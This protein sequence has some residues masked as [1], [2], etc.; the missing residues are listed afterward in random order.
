[1]N[2]P[3]SLQFEKWPVE[4]HRRARRKNLTI[5]LYPDRPIQVRAAKGTPHAMILDFLLAK[6][7]WIEKNLS[8]FENWP[9]VESKEFKA[10]EDFPFKGRDL[11]L[12]PVI[13][14]N[15]KPFVSATDDHLLLHIPRNDWS[16]DR[17][18]QSQPEALKEIRL[19][20]KR[21]SVR[22]L[23]RRVRHWAHEMKLLPKKVGYREQKTR[24]GSC[25]SQGHIQL[26]WRLIVFTP[27]VIDYVIIHELAHL[28]HMDHS[29]NF[30]NLVAQ[31]APNYKHIKEEMKKKQALCDFLSEKKR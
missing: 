16:A 13:T 17:M 14:L 31:F 6:K 2:S 22:E 26:N 29:A 1:M 21:E 8:R 18:W 12:K 7:S 5:A 11:K 30:W 24:W 23:D 28:K 20:Y 27:E 25:S 9:K 3:E 19:F 4:I 10:H 15:R